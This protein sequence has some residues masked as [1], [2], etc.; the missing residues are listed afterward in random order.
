MNNWQPATVVGSNP[1]MAVMVGPAGTSG[2]AS[3]PTRSAL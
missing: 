3:M 1:T 2:L